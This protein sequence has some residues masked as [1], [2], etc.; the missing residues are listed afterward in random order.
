[1]QTFLPYPGFQESA[2]VLDTQRLGKQLIECRQIGLALTDPDYGWKRHPAVL[3][4]KG[5]E[6]HLLDYAYQAHK[7]WRIR[8]GKPHQAYANMLS[9]PIAEH[10]RELGGPWW[11]GRLELHSSHQANLV[12][13][14]PEHYG[15]LFPG[16]EPSDVYWW[17]THHE[18]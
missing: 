6:T 14:D 15:K 5:Y 1:V 3:M 17:P 4:W 18:D 7:E 13:K 11:L 12:R 2:R 10:S 9:D 8:R 16:V